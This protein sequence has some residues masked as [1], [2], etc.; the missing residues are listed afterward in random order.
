MCRLLGVVTR[1]PSA[2]LEAVPEE[3][4]LF[5]A[6]SERHK[7][8]W[9]VASY[10]GSQGEGPVVRKGIDTARASTAYGEAVAEA[11]G[12]L[13]AVHLRRASK[14]LVL[15]LE[16]THPFVEGDVTFSHNGQFD[17][18]E[19]FREAVLARGGRPVEG[20][21]D[22]ELYFSL[23]TVEAREHGW[24]EAVQRAAMEVHRL[25]TGLGGRIPEGLN[26][27][28]TTP[29]ELVAYAHSDPDQLAEESPWD[30]YDLRYR[31]DADRVLVSSTGYPQPG[32][33][34]IEQGAAVTIR[35]GTLGVTTSA[36]R[37][38]FVPAPAQ[39]AGEQAWALSRPGASGARASL[40][41]G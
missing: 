24:A 2:L 15:R 9:G 21:T 27:L 20:T 19:G 17:M 28:L 35:R 31:A 8:G 4:P 3:L 1:R 16:N 29:D 26:C 23:I 34:S 40:A 22:S 25:V 5:T 33:T 11:D 36:P 7:D 37:E 32:F 14:G 12:D 18:P 41:V 13:T 39:L 6:L 30:T 38:D 10:G